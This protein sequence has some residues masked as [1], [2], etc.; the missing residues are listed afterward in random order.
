MADQQ[1]DSSREKCE[2]FPHPKLLNWFKRHARPLPWRREYRPY[3]IVMSEMMLQQTQMVTALP[4][5]ERWTQRWPNWESLA[6]AS[7]DEVLNMWEGL[8]YYQRARRLLKLAQVVVEEHGGVLPS[9]EH[10]LLALP[11]LGPYTTAAISAIAFNQVAFPIDG[12]VRRV[13]SRFLADATL[14]P[15]RAQ[16]ER[17]ERLMFP[18]F[19]ST[20]N[21]RGLAQAMMELGALV[22]SPKNPQ[23]DH[24]PLQQDCASGKPEKAM[25]YPVKKIKTKIKPLTVCYVWVLTPKGIPLRQ[26][27]NNGRFPS[28]WEPIVIE[29]DSEKNATEHM[30]GKLGSSKIRWKNTFVRNFTQFKVTWKEGFLRRQNSALFSDYQFFQPEELSK[31][32]LVPVMAKTWK[33]HRDGFLN[34]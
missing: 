15:S 28:Q 20:R 34:S 27:P 5:F 17:F 30:E 2:S 23:C 22:C 4:Y 19:K 24:C 11:G 32:N 9:D 12:N 14:S 7:E 31:L 13:L 29:T 21:R 25:A 18:S 3:D 10:Q 16:D 33:L 8:G 6:K 1:E 26:R